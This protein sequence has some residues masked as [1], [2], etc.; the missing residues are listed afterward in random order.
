[1]IGRLRAALW[2][3]SVVAPGAFANE[4]FDLCKEHK[5]AKPIMLNDAKVSFS[6][7]PRYP[8]GCKVRSESTGVE[9]HCSTFGILRN[10]Q[11]RMVFDC[12]VPSGHVLTKSTLEP[13]SLMEEQACFDKIR[14]YDFE[15]G[16]L[17]GCRNHSTEYTFYNA[18]G[19]IAIPATCQADLKQLPNQSIVCFTGTDATEIPIYKSNGIRQGGESD[20]LCKLIP[21]PFINNISGIGELSVAG[22]TFLFWKEKRMVDGKETAVCFGNGLNGAKPN[23]PA[24]NKVGCAEI[25][26]NGFTAICY[27]TLAG[28]R[29]QVDAVP[30]NPQAL[31][32]VRLF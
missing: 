3:V 2:L 17:F 11:G 22:Q 19:Q 5:G 32:E 6:P 12:E 13:F 9:L 1:M 28:E 24:E 23:T 20:N 7:S 30:I 29:I 26:I 8:E 27:D 16:T 18:Q 21:E 25:R 14:V 10:D 31:V 4:V 15:K